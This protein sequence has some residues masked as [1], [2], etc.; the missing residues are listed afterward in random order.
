MSDNVAYCDGSAR[1]TRVGE[2]YEFSDE[3]LEEMGYTPMFD[4]DT[5]LRRG[6]TWREDCYP[7]PG[8][9][10]RIYNANNQNVTPPVYWTGWPFDDYQFNPPPE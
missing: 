1:L 10:I 8:A 3:E 7:T 9:Q 2:L 4:Q 5:F 6:P